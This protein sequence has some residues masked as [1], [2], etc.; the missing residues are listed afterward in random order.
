MVTT[1]LTNI[2]ASS[3]GDT[4]DYLVTK[5]FRHTPFCA[6]HVCQ[7]KHLV[8]AY[9]A[10]HDMMCS[11][12][13]L[14]VVERGAKCDVLAVV[15]SDATSFEGLVQTE[16]GMNRLNKLACYVG[17][18]LYKLLH[19]MI[20][21]VSVVPSLASIQNHIGVCNQTAQVGLLASF[22]PFHVVSLSD[23]D[24]DAWTCLVWLCVLV[25]RAL[26]VKVFLCK[27]LDVLKDKRLQAVLLKQLS[28][29]LLHFTDFESKEDAQLV[30]E[31]VLVDITNIKTS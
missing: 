26:Q 25:K 5:K 14:V 4:E 2:A 24:V 20:F 19:R 13:C 22:M 31:Q 27:E 23:L 29:K 9:H 11:Q 28:P 12:A 8:I 6:D 17:T 16:L 10:L 21:K 7:P 3:L 30:L 1:L 18:R 15:E